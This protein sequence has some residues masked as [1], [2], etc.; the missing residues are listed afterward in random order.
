MYGYWAFQLGIQSELPLPDLISREGSPDITIRVASPTDLEDMPTP[1]HFDVRRDRAVLSFRNLGRFEIRQ[2]RQVVIHASPAADQ[3]QLQRFLVGT[4]MGV[5]LSQRDLTV[6]HASAVTIGGKAVAFIGSPGMGKSSMAAAMRRLGRRVLTDDIAA[7]ELNGPVHTVVP[8]YPR[9][10]LDREI[11]DCLGLDF[12]AMEPLQEGEAKRTCD[13]TNEFCATPRPLCCVY[14]LE[15]GPAIS[16]E[17]LRGHEAFLALVPHTFPPRVFYNGGPEHFERC[18]AL[19]ERVPL[20]RLKRPGDL[21]HLVDV[22]RFVQHH[23][24]DGGGIMNR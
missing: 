21:R 17:C 10:K 5:V 18:A 11:A 23:V 2:R 14:L 22:A 16:V 20:F 7:V 24:L 19:L 4:V 8:G 9:L 1:W 3:R 15:E 12:T 13:V 6:L